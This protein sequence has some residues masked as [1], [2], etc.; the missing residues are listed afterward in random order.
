MPTCRRALIANAATMPRAPVI[1]FMP[2]MAAAREASDV[3]SLTMAAHTDIDRGPGGPAG[4]RRDPQERDV[5]REGVDD[6][7]GEAEQAA[8][9][10]RDDGPDADPTT[11]PQSRNETVV[12]TA[13]RT[14]IM[15]TSREAE[16]QAVDVDEGVERDR[17]DEPAAVEA[18]RQGD[19]RRGRA[20]RGSIGASRAREKRG[21]SAAAGARRPA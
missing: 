4:D 13:A 14:P 20:V 6:Q 5:R 15:P 10:H 7:G 17:G 9:A 18:L 19:P 3:W 12:E 8:E 2:A 16:V 21:G 11:S 1:A